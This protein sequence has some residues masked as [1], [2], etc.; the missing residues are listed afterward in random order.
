[1]F[2]VFFISYA[3][4]FG[5]AKW[6][7]F[8]SCY[9]IPLMILIVGLS[10]L[11]GSYEEEI[12]TFAVGVI[13]HGLIFLALLVYATTWIVE[14]IYP[15]HEN[16]VYRYNVCKNIVTVDA[17]KKC[18]ISHEA[19]LEIAEPIWQRQK[20]D[21]FISALSLI[22]EIPERTEINIDE[23]IQYTY[24]ELTRDQK[25]EVERVCFKQR[26]AIK[27]KWPFEL[28]GR[29]A[30]KGYLEYIKKNQGQG[31]SSDGLYLNLGGPY[32]DASFILDTEN[33]NRY[34]RHLLNGNI[35]SGDKLCTRPWFCDA[36]VYGALSCSGTQEVFVVDY[37]D[38]KPYKYDDW[39][40][41]FTH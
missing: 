19:M 33:L 10:S 36:K 38:I 22:S 39:K 21:A 9:F 34:E 4:W 13:F 32:D 2:D 30:F 41:R 7:F 37:I 24:N 35:L 1:M 14:N 27:V 3:D 16:R 31:I 18:M 11:L 8:A 20:E 29:I 17:A 15:E 28:N 6:L 5:V 25:F 23:Y 26:G 12:A 40:K